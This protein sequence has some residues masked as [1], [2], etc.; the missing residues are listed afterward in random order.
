[1]DTESATQTPFPGGLL[2]WRLGMPSPGRLSGQPFRVGLSCRAGWAFLGK[3]QR[4]G[5]LCPEGDPVRVIVVPV[6]LEGQQGSSGASPAPLPSPSRFASLPPKGCQW[7]SLA[8]ILSVNSPP[9]LLPGDPACTSTHALL[10]QH[11]PPETGRA[12]RTLLPRTRPLGAALASG[13]ADTQALSR[14]LLNLTMLGAR[15]GGWPSVA[16]PGPCDLLID[17]GGHHRTASRTEGV[18]LTTSTAAN[19]V[20]KPGRGCIAS[21]QVSSAPRGQSYPASVRDK[22]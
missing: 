5:Q 14:V 2:R 12:A 4:L 17:Y 10:P 18:L 21:F 1:M 11:S 7:H 8:N 6:F 9:T 20:R 22:G 19:L 16:S 15:E 13:C 3:V